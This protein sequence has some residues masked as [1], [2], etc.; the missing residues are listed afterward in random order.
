M[1]SAYNPVTNYVLAM[2]IALLYFMQSFKQQPVDSPVETVAVSTKPPILTRIKDT[3]LHTYHGFRLFFLD[4]RISSRLL[5]KTLRGQS[6]S[7]REQKQVSDGVISRLIDFI[8]K[9]P[10]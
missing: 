5:L 10:L 1:N 7:R 3:A 4:L 8:I 9:K 6:L 2:L